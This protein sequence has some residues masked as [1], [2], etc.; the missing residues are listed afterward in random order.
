VETKL[1][2]G[3]AIWIEAKASAHTKCERC[4][5]QRADVGMHAE[6][7]TLCGRC[8]VNISSDGERRFF[9]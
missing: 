2:S 8:I 4:W 7:P 9:I 6:H 5:N 1:S 3:S